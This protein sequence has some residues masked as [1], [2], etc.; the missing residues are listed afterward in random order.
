MNERKNVMRSLI[1]DQKP[2]CAVERGGVSIWSDTTASPIYREEYC[3]MINWE[4]NQINR[5]TI[6]QMT[7]VKNHKNKIKVSWEELLTCNSYSL[8]CLFIINY[9]LLLCIFLIPLLSLPPPSHTLFI[10][11]YSYPSYNRQVYWFKFFIH[12]MKSLTIQPPPHLLLLH[13]SYPPYWAFLLHKMLT[14]SLFCS[15]RLGYSVLM[16]FNSLRSRGKFTIYYKNDYVYK[17]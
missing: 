11:S 16:L 17:Y 4:Y 9:I 7:I 1:N 6:W 5:M 2:I 10:S 14:L 3:I 8:L 12:E 13:P 15:I